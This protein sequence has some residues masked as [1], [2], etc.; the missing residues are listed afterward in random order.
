MVVLPLAEEDSTNN[1][2]G[3]LIE[4]LHTS[5]R[6]PIL[7]YNVSYNMNGNMYTEIHQH[8]SYI[9]LIAGPCEEWEEHTARYLQQLYELSAGNS[10]GHLW[11]PRAKF[12]VSVMSRCSHKTSTI[13]LVAIINKLW[14]KKLINIIVLFLNSSEHQGDDLQQNAKDSAQGTY[15]ELHTW[16]PYENSDRC[17]PAEGTVPVKVFTVRNLGDIRRRDIF[18]VYIDKNFQGCPIRTYVREFPPLVNE[19]KHI[20]YSESDCQTVYEDG[21]EIELL[22]I[23]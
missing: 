13:F 2:V 19:L 21:W 22:R 8:G 20:C 18:R 14:D 5:D 6:W 10:T 12:A 9:M 23:I 15:V 1:E 16:Y 3:Y 4:E 7:V 17:N 11:N